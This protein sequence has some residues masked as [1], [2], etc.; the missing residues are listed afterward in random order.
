MCLYLGPSQWALLSAIQPRRPLN[1]FHP[2][3]VPPPPSLSLSN[4]TPSAY[5][6]LSGTPNI[7]LAQLFSLWPKRLVNCR[8][9]P[10]ASVF[11]AGPRSI[12]EYPFGADFQSVATMDSVKPD[13]APTCNLR[14]VCG[15]LFLG[16]R[17]PPEPGDR[18]RG[19]ERLDHPAL[20]KHGR[21]H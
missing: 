18:Q 20:V 14:I 8:L 13:S 2:T 16:D 21:V 17:L 15:C 5:P 10:M 9:L 11:T 4:L 6:S 7:K 12:H 3:R 1:L 19:R